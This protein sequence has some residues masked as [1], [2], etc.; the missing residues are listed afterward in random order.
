MAVL[1][2]SLRAKLETTIKNAREVAEKASLAALKQLAIEDAKA[3]DYLTEAQKDLRRRLR[4]HGRALG[5]KRREDGSQE[6]KHLVWETSYEHWHQML[7]ARF[8]AENNLLMWEPG[9]AVSLDDCRDMVESHPELAM[10]AKSRWELAGKLASKM[11]P[12]VFKPKN[13]VF[14]INFSTEDQRALETLL[15][16]LLQEV[17]YAS[18]SLGWVYQFWQSK[19]KDE[20]NQSEVK[21]GAD[22]LPAVTQ[23]FTE[24]YMVEFLLQNSLGAWWISRYPKEKCPCELP[25]LRLTGDGLPAAGQ[26]EKWPNSLADFKLLDPSC[27]SG[28]FLVAAFLMLV[29]MRMKS[30]NIT[31]E[32]AV[33]SVLADNLYGLEIDPRCVEIAVFALA[34]SAWTYRDE[35][36]NQIGVFKKSLNFN[37]ACCGIQVSSKVGSWIDLVPNKL[38]NKDHLTGGLVELYST[39]KQSPILGS[40]LDPKK[41]NKGNL[42]AADYS[43]LNDLLEKALTYESQ[44]LLPE[45]DNDRL[46]TAI[47]AQGLLGASSILN[48]KY[49]LVITN[50]PYL[51]RGKQCEVLRKYCETYYDE[52]KHDLANVFLERCIELSKNNGE[53]VVQ[54]V[55]PQNWLFLSSYKKQRKSLLKKISWNLLARIGEGGFDSPQAAG[56]FV[57]L[58]SVTNNYPENKSSFSSIDASGVGEISKIDYLINGE[59]KVIE[60]ISQLNNPDSIINFGELKTGSLLSRYAACFEG[61]ST[62]DSPRFILKHWEMN[63]LEKITGWVPFVQ[64]TNEN[65]FYGGRQEVILWEEG[66]GRLKNFESAHNFPSAIMNGYKVLGGRG[67]RITQMRQARCTLFNGEV[68]G[69]SGGTLVVKDDKS[70]SAVWCYCNSS[71]FNDEVQRLNPS[72][73]KPVGTYVKVPFDLQKWTSIAS[74]EYPHGLPKPFSNDPTQW[75]FHGHPFG[76]VYWDESKKIL[77]KKSFRL[78]KNVLQVCIARLLGYRWPAEY[79]NS[80]EIS[81]ESK[82]WAFKNEE[83]SKFVK[84]DGVICLSSLR[85]EP[86]A[87]EVLLNYLIASWEMVEKN[88]WT[89]GVLTKILEEF[90]SSHSLENWLKDHFF[91]EHLSLFEHRPFIWHISDGLYDGFGILVNYHRLDKK[92]LEKIIHTYLGEWIRQ[93]EMDVKKNIDGAELRLSASKLL[94]SKLQNILEGE[95]PFDIF[96]RWKTIENQSLGWNPDLNDGV[97]LNIRPF[98][99]AEILRINKKPKFN[100]SWD[101]DRGKDSF[102]SP[103]YFLGLQYDGKKGDR[104]N[105]HHLTLDEKYKAKN[106]SIS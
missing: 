61:I 86:P 41:N 7:F 54:V 106:E 25:Y 13:P 53:G 77:D 72:I 100:I 90:G 16:S 22:E 56:A 9:A 11:L 4:A 94:K 28:H 48:G 20:V 42:F 35:N 79:L 65:I 17:F 26:F 37:V 102:D 97:R 104:I 40:L 89:P 99:K 92:L 78:D 67:L 68:F 96:V 46:E 93:Q 33:N 31:A 85:G 83:L 36:G 58:F 29:P 32:D 45:Y 63:D 34:I 98:L 6:L 8:L 5:D 10:G 82:Y 30:E 47:N 23:L 12:Q 24:P 2:K 44:P 81:D 3:P 105:A 75:L 91:V 27:G 88:V 74:Q 76:M 66:Q 73:Y 19:R 49:D 55:M 60:Q 39:F 87:H 84:S 15:D 14:E 1:E 51:T 80:I 57:I 38:P 71:E 103:W 21:I 95:K 101:K 70:L 62:G 43:L 64:N 18:D 52:A 59:I 50:V 69:K